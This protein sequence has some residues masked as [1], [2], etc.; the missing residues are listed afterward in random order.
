MHR[1]LPSARQAPAIWLAFDL[2][3]AG[4]FAYRRNALSSVNSQW[5]DTRIW[6]RDAEDDTCVTRQMGYVKR[7]IFGRDNSR[8]KSAPVI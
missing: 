3:I 7:T 6:M 1:H 4:S 2:K 8:L 5:R